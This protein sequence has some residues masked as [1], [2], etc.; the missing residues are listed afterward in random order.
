MTRSLVFK[1]Y[2]FPWINSHVAIGKS[3]QEKQYRG[4]LRS[5][6]FIQRFESCRYYRKDRIIRIDGDRS[7]IEIIIASRHVL[8]SVGQTDKLRHFNDRKRGRN[9]SRVSSCSSVLS[10][11]QSPALLIHYEN[12]STNEWIS[13]A[14]QAARHY[15]RWLRERNQFS[16]LCASFFAPRGI[17]RYTGS[18]RS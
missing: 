11:L 5:K 17:W 3:K 2:S 1:N 13:S 16:C 8:G 14:F 15:R 7:D 12:F 18:Y 10:H 9:I 6:I 4:I